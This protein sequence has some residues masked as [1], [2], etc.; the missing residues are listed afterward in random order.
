MFKKLMYSAGCAAVAVMCVCEEARGMEGNSVW[1]V[2]I[3]EEDV[4]DHRLGEYIKLG[5]RYEEDYQLWEDEGKRFLEKDFVRRYVET[6]MPP[7]INDGCMEHVDWLRCTFCTSLFF[8]GWVSYERHE[9]AK[10]FL[11]SMLDSY[12]EHKTE[13]AFSIK[14]LECLMELASADDPL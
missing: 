2:V 13:L 6:G 4:F 9:R 5:N 8:A 12:S 1:K 11:Q 3:P 10:T 14:Y 7:E